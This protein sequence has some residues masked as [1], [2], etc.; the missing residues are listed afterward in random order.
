MKYPSKYTYLDGGSFQKLIRKKK[1]EIKVADEMQVNAIR[2][3]FRFSACCIDGQVD[4]TRVPE[5]VHR[6]STKEFNCTKYRGTSK[7]IRMYIILYK[8]VFVRNFPNKHIRTKI[9]EYLVQNGLTLGSGSKYL[10]VA[11]DLQHAEYL[12]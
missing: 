1:K 11:V 3:S 2:V 9:H 7:I 12:L 8:E 10:H 5:C 4:Y 6:R